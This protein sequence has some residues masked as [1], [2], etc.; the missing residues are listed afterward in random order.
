[1]KRVAVLGAGAAGLIATK[2]CIENGFDV[3]CF[4]YSSDI[5]GLWNYNTTIVDGRGS[6]MRTTVINSSKEAMAFSDFPAPKHFA[7]YMHN[8]KIMEYFRLYAEQ[9]HLYEKIKFNT[10]VKSVMQAN[11]YDATGRWSITYSKASADDVTETFDAVMVCTGHHAEPNIPVIDTLNGSNAQFKGEVIHSWQYRNPFKYIDKNVLVVGVGN[12]GGDIAVE[13]SRIASQVYLSTRSGML[14]YPRSTK[15]VGWPGDYAGLTRFGNLLISIL[16]RFMRSSLVKSLINFDH[17]LY[18]IKPAS[19]K[20]HHVFIND[21][22]PNRIASGTLI[23]KSNFKE[24]Q[25]N[26]CIFDDGS[27]VDNIDTVILA[28]GYKIGFPILGDSLI[29][30]KNN[31]VNLYKYV[32]PP[33]LKHPTL[34]VMGCIQPIGAYNPIVELQARYKNEHFVSRYF[35]KTCCLCVKMGSTRIRWQGKVAIKGEN[36]K[37]YTQ[38]GKRGISAIQRKPKTYDTSGFYKLR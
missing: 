34:A 17:K 32:F 16:G 35:L 22:L 3:V 7:N 25:A 5:G 26:S 20:E 12:S 27:L 8:K 31:W 6:V 1:M 37:R 11:D 33:Q 13:L 36:G 21:D 2:I 28:T 18:A 19:D 29:E 10:K 30:V 9:F 4:E 38:Q 24:F 15:G 14:C 23:I